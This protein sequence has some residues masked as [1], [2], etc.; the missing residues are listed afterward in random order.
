MVFIQICVTFKF[1]VLDLEQKGPG[2]CYQN[3]YS[4][5][6]G[7]REHMM[8]DLRKMFGH[9]QGIPFHSVHAAFVKIIKII[10]TCFDLEESGLG[11]P[12]CFC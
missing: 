5:G 4:I 1:M 8:Y 11:S 9:I 12:K 10:M 3:F 6:V 7:K 2:A